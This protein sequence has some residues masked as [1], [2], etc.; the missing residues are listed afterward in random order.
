MGGFSDIHKGA[1]SGKNGETVTVA[2]KLLRVFSAQGNVVAARKRLNWEAYVWHRLEH[3]NIAQF[4]GTSYHMSGR[5][6][7]IMK[8]YDNGN[9]ADFLHGPAGASADRRLLTLDV[10]RGL[11]YLHTQVSPIIHGDLKS[12]NVLITKD[13]RAVLS[14]FGLSQVIQAIQPTGLTPSNLESGPT[15]WQALELH[16]DDTQPNI[17]TDMLSGNIPYRYCQRDASVIKAAGNHIKPSGPD[18]LVLLVSDVRLEM[19]LDQCWSFIPSER[20]SMTN[21]VTQLEGI[22]HATADVP[23]HAEEPDDNPEEVIKEGADVVEVA[24]LPNEDDEGAG[25]SDGRW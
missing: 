25:D 17:A 24:G 21:V 19:V 13:V 6:S 12:N 14:D 11:E 10:A 16:Q 18:G 1:W 2:I 5:P 23:C 20:P 8:W 7:L 9:A 4:F 22:I 3:P 15:R